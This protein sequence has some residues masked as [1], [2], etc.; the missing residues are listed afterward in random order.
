M[1]RD[2]A[3]LGHHW[4]PRTWNSDR[5]IERHFVSFLPRLCFWLS[6]CLLLL[7]NELFPDFHSVFFSLWASVLLFPWRYWQPDDVSLW[8]HSTLCHWLFVEFFSARAPQKM[9]SF[10]IMEALTLPFCAFGGSWP[11]VK[12]GVFEAFVFLSCLSPRS[13]LTNTDTCITFDKEESK[14]LLSSRTADCSLGN[15]DMELRREDG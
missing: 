12:V 13:Q 5:P 8:P 9:S 10:W 3:C 14:F 11:G 7:R 6:I 4:V 1:R 2:L 15:K